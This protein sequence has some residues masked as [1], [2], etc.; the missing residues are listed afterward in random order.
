MVRM[1]GGPPPA[2]MG[3]KSTM[4]PQ[5]RLAQGPPPMGNQAG[6]PGMLHTQQQQGYS[7]VPAGNQGPH[8]PQGYYTVAQQQQAQQHAQ[9]QAQAH[10]QH[11]QHQ[12]MHQMQQAQNMGRLS[13]QGGASMGQPV[14]Q[15]GPGPQPGYMN[16]SL[17][18]RQQMQQHMQLQGQQ[19]GNPP[20]PAAA[21]AAR[22]RPASV[23]TVP[24]HIQ[25]QGP[26]S[27]S[28]PSN[29]PLRVP[30]RTAA[31]SPFARPHTVDAQK[32]EQPG[33][34]GGG[35]RPPQPIQMNPAYAAAAS[36]DG[37]SPVRRAG[38]SPESQEQLQVG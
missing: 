23:A 22:Q 29:M 2:G 25:P 6:S 27:A 13:A 1:V 4:H 14:P 34:F 38:L 31:S 15:A 32:P 37:H 12:Q 5:V 36:E 26:D 11:Q 19:P 24:T 8:P 20:N 18:Q 3:P 10:A 21:L 35:G 16:G 30:S 28:S 17:V 9:A 33:P 7:I